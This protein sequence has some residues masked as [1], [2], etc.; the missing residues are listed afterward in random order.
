MLGES[1]ELNSEN[2]KWSQ[3]DG[4][5]IRNK[6]SLNAD[7]FVFLRGNMWIESVQCRLPHIY[8]LYFELIR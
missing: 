3:S 6:V 2:C 8:I 1:S 5:R 4:L 7:K